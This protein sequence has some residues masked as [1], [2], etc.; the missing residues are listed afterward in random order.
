MGRVLSLRDFILVLFRGADLSALLLY[1][2]QGMINV[3]LFDFISF[4]LIW[5][6]VGAIQGGLGAET[7]V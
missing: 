6:V 3:P 2:L 7:M 1:V 5:Y 4:E